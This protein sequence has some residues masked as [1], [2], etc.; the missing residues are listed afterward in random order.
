MT[1]QSLSLSEAGTMCI[2]RI[3][4]MSGKKGEKEAEWE[5]RGMKR[6]NRN[7]TGMKTEEIYASSA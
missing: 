2:Y 4:R 6:T 7:Q 3:K 5:E 1:T